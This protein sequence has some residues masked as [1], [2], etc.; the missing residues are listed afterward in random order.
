MK[1]VGDNNKHQEWR[2]AVS[3]TCPACKQVEANIVGGYVSLDGEFLRLH[4]E[5]IRSMLSNEEKR[6]MEDNPLSRIMSWSDTSDG[7]TV[8]TTTEHLAQR[9]GH[10]LERAYKGRAVYDFSH[11]NKVARVAWHRD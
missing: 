8:E 1:G 6:A 9:F 2:P 4:R 10:A 5:E 11:E 7:M 3:L